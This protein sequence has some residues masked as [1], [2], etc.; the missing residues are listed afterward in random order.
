MALSSAKAEYMVAIQST[1]EDIWMRK[2]LVGLF[3]SQMDPTVIHCDN[4][5]C[6]KLSI[7]PMFHDRSKHINIRYHHLRDYVE[8]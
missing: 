1:C 5:S 8:R 3:G 7:N 2:I 6:I 4:Q